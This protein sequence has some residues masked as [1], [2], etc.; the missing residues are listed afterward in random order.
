MYDTITTHG[1][2]RDRDP[3]YHVWHAML[4]RCDSHRDPAYKDY[5]GRGVKVCNRWRDFTVFKADMGPRPPDLMLE[6]KDVNGNYEPRN[7]CWATA[8]EQA[9]NRRNN[10]L[11]EYRGEAL[12]VA[13][14]AR[15]LDASKS[16]LL[17][18]LKSG[19]SIEEALTK[20]FD[21]S[22]NGGRRRLLRA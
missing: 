4:M 6:R 22:L 20:P 12:T 17:H 11:L 19:W 9:N 13:E 5:G 15:R 14:W 16:G 10:R 3:V 21:R 18:R 2:T 8:L 1:A 7:C